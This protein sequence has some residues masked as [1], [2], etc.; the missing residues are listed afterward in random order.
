MR[1]KST[2]I[3]DQKLHTHRGCTLLELAKVNYDAKVF[4]IMWLFRRWNIRT[5]EWQ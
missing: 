5:R 2:L 4:K 3:L 1:S